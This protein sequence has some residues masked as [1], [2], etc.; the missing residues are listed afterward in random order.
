MDIPIPVDL[1][2]IAQDLQ[3]RR[4]QVESVVQL[5][6]EGNTVPFITRYRKER[7]G[8]LNEVIIREIQLRV[9]RLR[10]LA[11]RKETIL[12][13][14]E[15][16]GKL[17]PDLA[18]AIRAA[19]NPK[20]LEDLY[21]PFKPK[22]RTKASDARERGPGAAGP[23]DLDPRRDADRRP[24]GR[25]GI[26]QR[27]E[28]GRHGREGAR[29]RRPHP[30]RGDQRDGHGPRR[31]PQ[32]RLEDR[33]DRHRQGRDPRGPGPGIP[34]LLRL[35]RAG[36]ADPAP[37][38]AGDQPRRQGR[39]AQGQ[40]RGLPARRGGRAVQPAPARGPS[41]ARA[42]PRGRHRRARPADPPQHGARGPSRPDRGGREAR[43]RGLRPQPGQPA[44]PAAD[45]QAGRPGHRSRVQERL[46]GRRARP[47]RP[48]GRP[49]GDLSPSPPESPVRGQADPQGHGRQAQGRRR[50]DRQRHRLP[51]DR[52]AGRRDH[53]RGDA[54]QPG[55]RR[56]GADR[57]RGR[58]GPGA[59]S[60]RRGRSAGGRAPPRARDPRA[61]PR[62]SRRSRRPARPSPSPR[63]KPT[64]RRTRR[65]ANPADP[66]SP[67]R[68]PRGG[69]GAGQC[70]EP[71]GAGQCRE[72]RGAGRGDGARAAAGRV[73]RVRAAHAEAEESLG[74]GSGV[75]PHRAH[76]PHDGHEPHPPAESPVEMLPPIS[77][78]APEG[79]ET[80]GA[81]A[82][83]PSRS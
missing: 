20:R 3:I 29:G 31:G 81:R 44:A 26:R 38:R 42:V 18:A 27:R 16:Q 14:I 63:R 8:N 35:H 48:A 78:G 73:P 39:P 10:E 11:E 72:P 71:R 52:G 57:G 25:R 32:G 83:H 77:G 30:R 64:Q 82:R 24:R 9:Q 45:P 40:A 79:D 21:L 80:K 56:H 33:Q 70:R 75:E 1:G 17:D 12:K 53:R 22:K 19:D 46:Q 13:A 68:R 7:T 15:A 67:G 66:T 60:R 62:P 47:R 59:A 61:M 4:V 50:G 54:L 74:N 28:G 51:R 41:P 37:P 49:G 5:L 2:R 69:P 6:D 76:E 36:L 65:R 55:R 43:R 34:R 58:A 23:A